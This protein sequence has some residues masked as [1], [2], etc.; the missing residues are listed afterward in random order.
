MGGDGGVIAS[1]RKFV[2]GTKDPD[3]AEEVKHVRQNQEF[4]ARHCAQ[5]STKLV[6][7][8]VCCELG[9]LYSKE[10]I[11]TALIE[12]SMNP[13]FAH[14]RGLKDI[15]QL[16]FVPNPNY[17]IA[18]EQDGEMPAMFLCPITNVEFNGAQPFVAI[19][20]TGH[21]LSEKALRE[22]GIDA[23]QADY[24]PF[25]SDDVI[26][27]IPLDDELDALQHKMVV[28]RSQKK[29][30]SKKRSSDEK[31]TGEGK[32]EVNGDECHI[33]KK[34]KL[35]DGES[36]QINSN[37]GGGSSNRSSVKKVVTS[38]TNSSRTVQAATEAISG[39]ES[40]SK[41]FKD[42]FHKGGEKDKHDRDL[43]MS[44]SGL[45]YSLK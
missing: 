28:R 33:H 38:L 13:K 34:S 32:V 35:K 7:P 29:D 44:V 16:K 4:R 10:A 9:N 39:Q 3:A 17:S 12:K 6:E 1:Q 41:V 15:K 20:T 22:I 40:S 14:I 36:S 21:V 24:G 25:E 5:S 43:F 31:P 11:L 23:L 37:T 30:K 42:L 27:L 18:D 2:R 8:I 26:K 45:R 19:W